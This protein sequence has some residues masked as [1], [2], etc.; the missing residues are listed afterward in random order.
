LCLPSLSRQ[1]P[2]VKFS[3][4][5]P[6]PQLS[7]KLEL[8]TNLNVQGAKTHEALPRLDL[9]R[10]EVDEEEEE[11]EEAGKRS[12]RQ[13]IPQRTKWSVEDDRALI[14]AF[15]HIQVSAGSFVNAAISEVADKC[16]F[17]C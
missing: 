8:P 11:A 14:R 2:R 4:V 12:V 17:A 1:R 5:T 3:I 7:Q 15:A 16:L 9:E 13:V 6:H 10:E